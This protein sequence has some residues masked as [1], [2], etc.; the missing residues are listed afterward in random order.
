MRFDVYPYI[1]AFSDGGYI[2]SG[3]AD[4]IHVCGSKTPNRPGE[5]EA[6][7]I[8]RESTDFVQDNV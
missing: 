8:R 1:E 6:N 4:P 7:Q 5:V 3:V 2:C